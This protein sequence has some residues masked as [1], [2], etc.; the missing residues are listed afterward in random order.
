[1]ATRSACAEHDAIESHGHALDDIAPGAEPAASD[2]DDM[3]PEAIPH[4][5]FMADGNGILHVHPHLAFDDVRGCARSPA[6]PIEPD[7]D[8]HLIVLGDP[9]KARYDELDIRGWRDLDADR[10]PAVDHSNGIDK[11]L[12]VLDGVAVMERGRGR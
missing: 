3:V 2:E 12:H 6:G 5:L 10:R 11:G 7:L 4:Q 1:M 9:G 8:H